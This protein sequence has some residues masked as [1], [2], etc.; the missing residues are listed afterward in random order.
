M[1]GADLA[2]VANGDAV[3]L[4]LVDQIVGHRLA[5]VGAAV[6]QSHERA[7]ACEPDSRLSRGVAAADDRDPRSTASFRLRRAGRVEHADSLEVGEILERE[8]PIVGA[9]REHD[10]AARHL[11]ALLQPDDMVSVARLERD[12]AIRS[13]GP[14][15]EL[16]R[17]AD[18]ATR[19]L[20]AGDAGREAEI[21][22]DPPRGSRLSA[23]GGALDEQRLQALRAP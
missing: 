19:Q 23:E 3:A 11:V 20:V 18:R 12:R 17:L 14:G 8:P 22:L 6:E 15:A 2:A 9:G 4:E 13:S 16:A 5:Q 21:V 10:G 7:A 1:Q